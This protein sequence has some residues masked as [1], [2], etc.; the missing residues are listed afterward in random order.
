MVVRRQTTAE[1]MDS[2]LSLKSIS[3][4]FLMDR[5]FLAIPRAGAAFKGVHQSLLRRV[6][7]D[8]YPTHGVWAA[9]LV[10]LIA[11]GPGV[12]S[13]DHLLMRRIGEKLGP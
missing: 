9:V 8:A 4:T 5:L 7:P 6:A 11:H 12:V 10:F 13:V 1:I 2:L 3:V